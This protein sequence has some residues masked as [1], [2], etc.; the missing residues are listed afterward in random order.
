MTSKSKITATLAAAICLALAAIAPASALAE[1]GILDINDGSGPAVEAPAFPGTKAIWAGTCDLASGET[2]HGGTGAAPALRRHCIDFG[3][4]ASVPENDDPWG[5]TPH[6]SWRLDPVAQA[7]AHPDASAAFFFDFEDA[8]R[9]IIVRLPPGVVGSPTAVPQCSAVRSQFIPPECPAE[10]QVGVSSLSLFVLGATDNYLPVYNIEARDT[11]TAEF[12]IANA[13]SLFN[14]PVTARGR[15]NGDYG[16]D[17][18]AL[19]VPAYAKLY[20]QAFTFWG[21][22][23]SASHDAFRLEGTQVGRLNIIPLNGLPAAERRPYQASWGPIKPFFTN[24]TRCQPSPLTVGIDIDSWEDPGAKTPAGSA[25]VSDPNWKTANIAQELLTG[26]DKLKFDPSIELQ[27]TVAV[28][29]SPSGLDV[30]LATPQNED[31]P[32]AVAFNSSEDTGAPA[33]WKTDAG[34]GAAHLRNT[35]IQLPA[36]TSFNPAAADGLEGCTTKQVGLTATNPT[37]FD[38]EKVTC[39]ESSKIGTL[40]IDTPLLPDPLL[41]AVYAAPQ[42]DNPYPGSLTAIYLV[43]QDDERGLSVKLSGKIDLD[44]KTGQ[45]STTFVDNPQLPFDDFILHLETGPRAALSTPAT[46]GQFENSADLVPWSF[47]DSGPQPSVHDPFAINAA[48]SGLACVQRP[49]DRVFKPGFSAGSSSPQAGAHT[50]FVLNVTRND[51]EQEISGIALDMPPGLTASLRGVAYCTEAQIAA[52]RAKTGLQETNSASCP[53]SSYIG[54]AD[55]LAG[56]GSQP[57]HTGGKLYLAGPYDPDGVGPKPPAPLSVVTIVPAIAGGTPGDPTFDLGNVVIHT[58]V[59]LDPN[60]AQVKI[61]S[62]QVPYIV[63]GVPLRVRRVSVALD[64]PG[65]MLNPTNCAAASV[66]GT[67]TGAADPL[68][69]GDDV[70]APVS[71]RFE[72]GGCREL[73]F[74]P[75]LSVTLNGGTKRSQFPALRAVVRAGA[76]E[77]NIAGA[78]VRL[79]H[80]E[81]LEQGHIRTVCTRVQF[82]AKQCPEGSIYGSATAISPLLDQPLTGPVYLRSNPEHEL[83]DIVAALHGQVDIN[84]VGRIDSVKGGIRNTFE[85]VPDAPVSEF[86]LNMQGGKKGLLVNSRNICTRTKTVRRHGKKTKK[87][88][89][90]KNFVDAVFYG[91]NGKVTHSNVAIKATGCGKAKQTAKSKRSHRKG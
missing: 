60:N 65:F 91:Q 84:V 9:D 57:L 77:A 69:P 59:N 88:V 26:C 73:G 4:V 25:D 20:G 18:L 56:S 7:G 68:N 75:Q 12:S 14:V 62:T 31:A 86:I 66:G 85:G 51:G 83:P 36:G 16:V 29:D 54:K 78:A 70:A 63:G 28:A 15:T 74:G 33:Y 67:L 10:A 30:T 6:P 47:P 3:G 52:A 37:R 19:L 13:G 1:F 55:T 81:F 2:S 87:T 23:W 5:T 48:P 38:N 58:A 89:K 80:S 41:G 35:T 46:C 90:T 40:Q 64:R 34:L 17:T 82:A 42:D 39:P 21:V 79:P 71:N 43:A 32:D 11:I 76:G 44:P 22:P 24:P 27:P 49:Q 50:S 45:I 61:D 8:P 72:V 53:A